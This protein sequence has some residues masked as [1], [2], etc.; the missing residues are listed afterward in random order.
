MKP[1]PSLQRFALLTV[2]AC[3][4]QPMPGPAQQ[5]A[6]SQPSG[7]YRIAGTVVNAVTGEPVHHAAVAA[8]SEEDSHTVAA[9]ESDN[10]GH[11]SLERLPAAKYQ[12]TA[13]KR[14]FR[15]SF[16]DEHEEFNSAVV[17]GPGQPT[18][19][20]IFR[21]VP[22]GVVHGT[23]ISDGGDPVEGARVLLFAKEYDGKAGGRINQSDTATTDDTGAYE[24][25]GL[26]A[27]EYM[28]AVTA[29]PW[30]ALHRSPSRAHQQAGE[31]GESGDS[32]SP[33]P[34][35]GPERRPGRESGRGLPGD[36]LR[37]HHRRSLG[38]PHSGQRGQ[39]H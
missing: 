28:L 10:E 20:L 31:D 25:T 38:N 9:V 1:H 37:F 7:I 34:A 15:A 11:F 21:L 19:H 30:Y 35:H 39:P 3:A 23:V 24:F 17:T 18:D 27:G 5:P 4:V 32:S 22:G 6:L 8:L 29:E 33:R 26:A 13:S 16:Y 12:L 36:L 14:G 2:A